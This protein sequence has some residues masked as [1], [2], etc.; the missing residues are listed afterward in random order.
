MPECECPNCGHV[1]DPR[2]TKHKATD[3][4][5]TRL[6]SAWNEHVVNHTGLPAIRKHGTSLRDKLGSRLKDL[7]KACDGSDTEAWAIIGDALRMVRG[8]EHYWKVKPGKTWT[9][10]A[11]WVFESTDRVIKLADRWRTIH[12]KEAKHDTP[13]AEGG[14][15]L[16]CDE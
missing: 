7:R 13:H 3:E 16:V 12:P 4:E 10:D 9:A 15:L 1:W 6:I 14:L 8:D 11:I 5:W 2:K